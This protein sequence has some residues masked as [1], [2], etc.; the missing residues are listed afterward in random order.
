[1]EQD[2]RKQKFATEFL[3]SARTI[4]NY[5]IIN[6]DNQENKELTSFLT[7]EI[8]L[9]V[10]TLV[11]HK[12]KVE[13]TLHEI[14]NGH[15]EYKE[16]IY[17]D[18]DE[19]VVFELTAKQNKF[20]LELDSQFEKEH[21]QIMNDFKYD[22]M[23]NEKV[24]EYAEE[25]R[26]LYQHHI[27]QYE[28]RD[29]WV[30]QQAVKCKNLNRFRADEVTEDSFIKSDNDESKSNVTNTMNSDY[31]AQNDIENGDMHNQK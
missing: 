29:E 9:F 5:L 26:H 24:K 12:I 4:E 31:V 23:N 27:N 7:T 25:L 14:E 20:A 2:T 13:A 30:I 18:F 19:D 17:T 1:M 16:V 8:P 15:I 21:L 10:R 22:S 11:K 3:R 28:A 6:D